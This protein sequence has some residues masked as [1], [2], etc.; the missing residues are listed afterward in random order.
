GVGVRP[1]LGLHPLI[2]VGREE[3]RCF[4]P[5]RTVL[6]KLVAQ[7]LDHRSERIDPEVDRLGLR[8]DR[9]EPFEGLRESSSVYWIDGPPEEI[10]SAKNHAFRASS[11][12][13]IDPAESLAKRIERGAL[14]DHPV[15]VEVGPR[16]DALRGHDDDGL[17]ILGVVAPCKNAIPN[18]LNDLRLVDWPH[19][20][21]DE[22]AVVGRGG[23]LLQQGPSSTSGVDAIEDY[24][25]RTAALVEKLACVSGSGFGDDGSLGLFGRVRFHLDTHEP[26]W[27]A[28]RQTPIELTRGIVVALAVTARERE[29]LLLLGA[30]VRRGRKLDHAKPTGNTALSFSTSKPF[31]LI[32]HIGKRLREMHFVQEKQRITAE[33]AG[34]NGAHAVAHAIATEKEARPHLIDRA[35]ADDGHLRPLCPSVVTDG[36]AT[37]HRRLKEGC[38]RPNDFTKALRHLLRSVGSWRFE[39]LPNLQRALTYLI[40]DHAPV[41]NEHDAPRDTPASIAHELVERDVDQTRLA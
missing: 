15:E 39:R 14:R 26:S 8:R 29:H 34:M 4:A 33:E 3:H 5:W 35:R 20:A 18:R 23:R 19:A 31:E 1:R 24:G 27:L 21:S 11:S 37:K 9:F 12:E 17:C 30:S 6:P 32:E 25:H 40:D 28:R 13:S 36:G 10:R 2:Q 22:N 38:S 16:F 7:L 41:H